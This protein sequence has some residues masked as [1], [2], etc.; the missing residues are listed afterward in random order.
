MTQPNPISV[1]NSRE[2]LNLGKKNLR[3]WAASS[4]TLNSSEVGRNHLLPCSL[5]YSEDRGKGTYTIKDVSSLLRNQMDSSGGWMVYHFSLAE[6]TLNNFYW[7]LPFTCM[8]NLKRPF[9]FILFASH[10]WIP[11]R[12][13]TISYCHWITG[14]HI[15]P[16]WLISLV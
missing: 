1:S 14:K 2:I 12:Q 15:G 6:F 11:M 3:L 16:C 8:S 4:C 13:H 7:L 10:Q 5:F 9:S